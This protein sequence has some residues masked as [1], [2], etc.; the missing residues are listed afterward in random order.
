MASLFF[1]LDRAQKERI[2]SCAFHRIARCFMKRCPS[3]TLFVLSLLVFASCAKP[4]FHAPPCPPATT[5]VVKVKVQVKQSGGDSCLDVPT[6]TF[7]DFGNS[8]E[9]LFSGVSSGQEV[10]IDFLPDYGIDSNG[11]QE[12]LKGPF[13]QKASE[14]RNP[15]RGRYVSDVSNDTPTLASTHAGYWKYQVV[16]HNTAGGGDVPKCTPLD[17]GLIVKN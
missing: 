16:L 1:L 12:L 2:G 14:P 3:W 15:R 17:P 8:L 6:L 9:F 11:G 4:P 13:P 10:E 7:I 5:A